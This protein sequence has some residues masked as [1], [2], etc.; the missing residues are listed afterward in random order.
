MLGTPPSTDFVT[1]PSVTATPTPTPAGVESPADG[2]QAPPLAP[3]AKSTLPAAGNGQGS[4]QDRGATAEGPANV[5]VL[6]AADAASAPSSEVNSRDGSSSAPDW[7]VGAAVGG[8]V[9]GAVLLAAAVGTAYVITK[10][11][12]FSFGKDLGAADLVGPAAGAAA[13]VGVSNHTGVTVQ[14]EAGEWTSGTQA[15]AT[16]TNQ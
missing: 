7:A 12:R 11:K 8:A 4:I 6:A 13:A 9:G 15:W 14:A 16:M 1:E 3:A 5:N 2:P 10:R